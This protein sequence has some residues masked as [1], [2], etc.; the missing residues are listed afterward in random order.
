MTSYSSLKLSR[1]KSNPVSFL[2]DLGLSLFASL[3]CILFVRYRSSAIPDFDQC[4]VFWLLISLIAS[5]LGILVTR[6][7]RII[8][9]H[10][11]FVAVFNVLLFVLLKSVLIFVL[12]RCLHFAP[13][14]KATLLAVVACDFFLTVVFYLTYKCLVIIH[15]YYENNSIE[16]A[17]Q[18]IDILIY[19]VGPKSLE[20]ALRMQDSPDYNLVGFLTRSEGLAE[21][22]LL[23]HPVYFLT[24]DFLPV[25]GISAVFFTDEEDR[26]AES[27]GIVRYAAENGIM[28]MTIPTLRKEA[29]IMSSGEIKH[30]LDNRY[31]ADNM[32]PFERDFKRLID[33]VLS[34]IL[35][36]LTGLLMV[37]IG[38][39][40]AL[41]DGRPVI[42]RQERIGRFGRPFTILKFRTMKVD[43][44]AG[45]PALYAGDDDPRLT[46]VGRFLRVHH[47]DEL[48]Q[49]F[50]ILVGDMSF[51]GHRPER[52]VYI[53]EII[54]QDPRYAYLYQM[55]P[56]V[57]SYA[58]LMNGYTDNMEK[59]LRRLKFDLYYLSH[60]SLFFDIKVIFDTFVRVASGK[61]F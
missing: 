23:D 36:V 16:A 13:E 49:L 51:V 9:T 47:L 7:H 37:G 8:F 14:W 2:L 34:L 44:E 42:F 50:N 19:G 27:D 11:S 59:M 25:P 10:A 4:L 28:V 52:K 1:V 46:R 26:R 55:R 40:V 54:K 35:I 17:V 43:A 21:K 3:V 53:T 60:R 41:S 32:S 31:I 12:A 24:G 22:V 57:T 33:I 48:P 45:G 5:F 30:I 20:E 38:I 15:H 18:K 61:R 29:N 39:V 58:T 56:G 6:V